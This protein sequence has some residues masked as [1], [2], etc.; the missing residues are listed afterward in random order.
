MAAES[1]PS[2]RA[3]LQ[4]ILKHAAFT[5]GGGSVTVVALERDFVD[6]LHWLTR[7]SFRTLYGLAR[8]TPGTTILALITGLGWTFFRWR[9]AL[10]ALAIAAIPGAILAVLFASAYQLLL[11]NPTARLFLGGAAAAVTGFIAASLWRIV[12]P[13]WQS[14]QRRLCLA[15]YAFALA[16][17][18]A[19]APPFPVILGLAIAGFFWP[20]EPKA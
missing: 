12:A 17:T 10:A 15:V 18:I 13:Y 11:P 1:P 4:I 2:F 19:G 16:L 9:G 14:S 20:P 3:F 6:E 8:L 7:D 5:F